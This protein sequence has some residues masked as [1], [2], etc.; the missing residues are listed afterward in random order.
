MLILSRNIGETLRIGKEAEIEIEAVSHDQV[1]LRVHS[2][3]QAV[4]SLP[5][6]ARRKLPKVRFKRRRRV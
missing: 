2:A 5:A 3:P 1:Q 6:P 4:I